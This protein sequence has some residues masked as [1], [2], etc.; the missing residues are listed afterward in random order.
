MLNL[1]FVIY[2]MPL[3]IPAEYLYMKLVDYLTY[4]TVPIRSTW[5][6]LVGGEEGGGGLRELWKKGSHRSNHVII[7][8]FLFYS[9]KHPVLCVCKL[10]IDWYCCR[11]VISVFCLLGDE[12][13]MSVVGCRL[14]TVMYRQMIVGCRCRSFILHADCRLSA[15][16]SQL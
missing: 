7:Y 1:L 3:P 10:N 13:Q 4:W 5:K 12:C 8:S 9:Y 15:V 2:I 6:T 14:S 16:G 11:F